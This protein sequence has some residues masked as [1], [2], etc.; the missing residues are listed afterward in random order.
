MGEIRWRRLAIGRGRVLGFGLG[1]DR[2]DGAVIDRGR[3]RAPRGALHT[4]PP[5]TF[6]WNSEQ[7]ASGISRARR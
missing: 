4:K 7:P 2:V 1:V 3:W 6:E 5:L